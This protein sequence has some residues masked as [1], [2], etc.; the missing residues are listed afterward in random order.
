MRVVMRANV[1]TLPT[2][3]SFNPVQLSP[4]FCADRFEVF[5]PAP[6]IVALPAGY[7]RKVTG[8]TPS[9]AGIVVALATNFPSLP[10]VSF[11]QLNRGLSRLVVLG[12]D[13]VDVSASRPARRR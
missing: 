10:W 12:R 7:R 8:S 9:T 5:Q 11:P 1:L 6:A 4:I 3:P 2:P 13:S